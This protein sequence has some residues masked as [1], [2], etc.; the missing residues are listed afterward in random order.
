MPYTNTPT[1]D[2]YSSHK[3]QLYRENNPRS[4]ATVGTKDED[5][6]NLLFSFIKEKNSEDIR[7]FILK[8]AGTESIV[9]SVAATSVRG[10]IFW[11]DQSKLLYCV[12]R[13]VYVYNVNTA[14]STT[15]TNVFATSTGD[16]GFCEFEYSD[17][18]TVV[19]CGTDGTA[20]TGIVTISAANAVTT[21][22]D[23]DLPAHLP[24]L[25]YLDGYLFVAKTSSALLYNSD[26]NL[27]LSWSASGYT[28][29][30]LEADNILK[31]AKIN[32]YLIAMGSETIEYFWDAANVAPGSPLQR[33]DTPIKINSYLG[34]FAVY[35]NSILYIGKDAGGQPDVFMLKDFKTEAVGTPGLARYLASLSDGFANWRGNIVSFL[36]HSYYVLTAGSYT[37]MMD[38]DTRLWAKIA[39][40]ALS[41]FPID[42]AITVTTSSRIFPYFSFAND[43]AILRFNDTLFSDSGVNYSCSLITDANAF[44]TMNRKTMSRCSIIGDRPP[45]NAYILIQWSDDDYQSY[46]TGISVNLN[47]DLPCAYRLGSFRQRIFKLTF[48]ADT[49]FRINEMEVDINKGTR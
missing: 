35:G 23:V 8:R 36:G 44:D 33:N 49:L 32:N 26:L 1:A 12:G 41:N 3:V 15:L 46:N 6:I 39:Y 14:A 34:G 7:K 43:S 4:G 18:G 42:K 27:P 5:N 45:V 29:A 16:V 22:N 2:T 37:Y 38:V 25:V 30:E 48:S 17:T 40:Q 11:T 9:T 24:Q 28:S 21:V 47:Q 31:I 20:Q 13:N 10:W 19:I